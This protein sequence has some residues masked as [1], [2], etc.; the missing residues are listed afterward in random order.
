MLPG[1]R[2]FQSYLTANRCKRGDGWK[3]ANFYSA[4]ALIRRK[5]HDSNW[6]RE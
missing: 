5:R 4:V 1:T 2:S 6:S 3:S